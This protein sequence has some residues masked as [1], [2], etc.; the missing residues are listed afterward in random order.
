MSTQ[1]AAS[2]QQR[3]NL[4]VNSWK[5]IKTASTPFFDWLWRPLVGFW[6]LIILAIIT[7][8]LGNVGFNLLQSG[9]INTSG[10]VKVVTWL[11]AHLALILPIGIFLL[12]MTLCSFIAQ[13]DR[14]SDRKPLSRGDVAIVFRQSWEEFKQQSDHGTAGTQG[15]WNIPYHRNP[16]FTGRENILETLHQRLTT[17]RATALTQRQ[18]ISGLGGIGKTQ[19]A[20]E[21]AY[22]HREDYHDVL[23]VNA[24]TRGNIITSF[25][26]LA[27]LLNLPQRDEADQSRI[28][29]AVKQWFTQ[30][31]QW[32]LIFDNADDLTLIEDFLPASDRGALLL[33]TRDQAS[34]TLASGIDIPTLDPDDGI[35]L[36]LRRAGVLAPD[37]EIAS[38]PEAEQRQAEQIVQMLGG[39]PLALDQSAAYI[40]ETG[41]SLES[42]RDRYQRQHAG[43]LDRR[44]RTSHDHPASVAT[45]W[46][47]S[48]EQ[49]QR[50]SPLAADLLRVCAF[51]APDEIAEE[52]LLAGASELGSHLA[53]LTDAPTELDEALGVLRRY[54]LVKRDR[55][56]RILSIHRLVQAVLQLDMNEHT[57]RT[58]ADRVVRAVNQAFPVADFS[59]WP[60]CERALHH[61]QV[62]STLIETYALQTEEAGVLLGR[63]G[64]YL[65]RRGQY[66][67][68]ELLYHRALAIVKQVL[69]EEHPIT[70]AGLMI[71]AMLYQEQGKY[72]EAEPLYQRALSIREQSLG[73]QHPDTLLS[74]SNLALFYLNLGKVAEAEPLLQRILTIKEQL[75]GPQHLDTV[76]GLYD[77]AFLYQSQGRFEEAEPL[78][79]RALAISEQEHDPSHLSIAIALSNLA[80]QYKDWGRYEKAES[81][82]QRALTIRE[83]TLGPDHPL[84]ATNLH[85][86]AFLYQSQGR[87]EEAEPLYQR[88][89]TI[90]ER[91]LEPQHPVT[92]TTR[93][94]YT[95]LQEKIRQKKQ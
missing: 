22:R 62:C 46:V 43:L 83:Q 45:T 63:T 34:G 87:Y 73:S 58:W 21:Y 33:T 67:E 94:E 91:V 69:G 77:L 36:L 60:E 10:T 6:T 70:A 14:Q 30:H 47:L 72:G 55:E 25:V 74:L 65:F 66:T 40:E 26:A 78:L 81:L 48:F 31:D 53:S 59:N 32:L 24:D 86:L 50:Q 57:R 39:L 54:S 13:R 28:V 82:L 15:V 16:F 84:T 90:R 19:I 52:L 1:Q 71:L 12:V 92:Q 29:A 88:A 27:A 61:A 89:L 68:V 11:H 3:P 37:A 42:Y 95:A 76:G 2:P 41:C 7:G 17:T 64:F 56:R 49:V 5:R 9:S 8:I 51:L 23:W 44:G 38:A 35:T 75:A 93:E 20:V 79:Q 18:A 4:L 80:N 85:E